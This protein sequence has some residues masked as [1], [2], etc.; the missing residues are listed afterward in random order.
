MPQPLMKLKLQ[1]Q[2]NNTKLTELVSFPGRK[3]R[4]KNTCRVPIVAQQKG[5]RLGTMRLQVRFLALLSQLKI[6]HCRELWCR[7]QTWLRSHLQWLWHR[8][9]SVAP[10]RPQAWE[11]PYAMG[12]VWPLKKKKKKKEYLEEK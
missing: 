2:L 11:P 7:L 3:K 5:I 10:I 4:K 6:Q 12:V 1:L 9:A 8:P